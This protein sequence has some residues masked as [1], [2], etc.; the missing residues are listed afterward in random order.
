MIFAIYK[1]KGITSAEALRRIK[2]KIGAEKIGHAGTLDPL[3][4]GVLVVAIGR[5][6]TKK[7]GEIVGK[8]KE[9]LATIK[10]GMISETDDSE[11]EKTKIDV[12]TIPRKKDIESFLP[13]FSGEIWQTP[14]IYSAIKIKG[15]EAYKLARKG[16]PVKLNPR[17][18]IIK[19]IEILSYY[20]PYL[21]LRVI[22]GPGVYIRALARD[23]GDRLR[24]GG[25]LAALERVR[26][27][28]FTKEKALTVEDFRKPSS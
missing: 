19:K 22:T 13:E 16:K 17:K 6:A 5:E 27:G 1:P 24:T 12:K 2:R 7:L 14:P 20:W 11:G 8:E 15:K 26:V 25:Y 28:D 21:R 9:Y 4:S 10:L 3:A 23:L 18:V